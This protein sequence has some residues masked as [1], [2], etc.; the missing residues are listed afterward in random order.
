MAAVPGFESPT[1]RRAFGFEIRHELTSQDTAPL[2]TA[3][4]TVLVLHTTEG[5][6]PE[7][8]LDTF[9]ARGDPPHWTMDG[10]SLFLVIPLNRAAK[11]LRHDEAH[12]P[13]NPRGFSPNSCAIQFEIVGFSQTEPWRLDEGKLHRLAA[14]MAYSAL[15]LGLGLDA[16]AYPNA[17]WRDDKSDITTI[18]ASNNTRRQFAATGFRYPDAGPGKIWDHCSVPFQSPTNHF[19]CG[20]LAIEGQILPQVRALMRSVLEPGAG[21]PHAPVIHEPPAEAPAAPP[22]RPLTAAALC[23]ALDVADIKSLRGIIDY[24]KGV[25]DGRNNRT[26]LAHQGPLYDDG[27]DDGHKIRVLPAAPTEPEPVPV[28]EAEPEPEPAPEPPG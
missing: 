13:A 11:A 10:D 9:E 16:I 27:Y 6:S 18:L 2:S 7:S 22:E 19:D 5:H 25:R 17:A 26:P 14:A 21:A 12:N 28:P 15:H 4:D 20:L 23:D 8:A 3:H 24:A 1:P